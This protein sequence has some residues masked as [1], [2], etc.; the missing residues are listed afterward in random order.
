MYHKIGFAKL[1][2]CL[3]DS[4]VVPS[5]PSVQFFKSLEFCEKIFVL[6][7]ISLMLVTEFKSKKK[8]RKEN[9]P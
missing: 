2:A 3:T 8:K 7:I 4:G 6:F 1:K 5:G 9:V